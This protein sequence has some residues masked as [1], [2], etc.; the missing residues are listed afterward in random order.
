MTALSDR[1]AGHPLQQPASPLRIIPDR[2][3]VNKAISQSAASMRDHV[4]GPLARHL[5]G[6][7]Y[8]VDQ[9]EQIE[10]MDTD[11]AKQLD[12]QGVDWMG[13][14]LGK[15]LSLHSVP[16]AARVQKLDFYTFT[17]RMELPTGNHTEWHRMV[18]RA[19][20]GWQSDMGPVLTV[21]A[22]IS[23][24]GGRCMRWA[25]VT[26]RRLYE[27]A[28]RMDPMDRDQWLRAPGGN[29]FLAVPWGMFGDYLGSEFWTEHYAVGPRGQGA[30]FA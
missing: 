30:L 24:R 17:I 14:R 26:T 2:Q 3:D 8:A 11:L 29:Y 19:G 10:G 6:T 15:R 18:A 13:T 21:Q 12:R 20:R 28:C 27:A 23:E 9:W 25:A 4:L 1:E 7:E 16:V 5:R 22:Y